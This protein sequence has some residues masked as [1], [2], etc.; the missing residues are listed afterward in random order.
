MNT[1]LRKLRLLPGS[2]CIHLS[3]CGFLL[4]PFLP[5]NLFNLSTPP[6]SHCGILPPL[7]NRRPRLADDRSASRHRPLCLHPF[8]LP[9]RSLSV[10]LV[11]TMDK[12]P[13]ECR[14]MISSFL[15]KKDRLNLSLTCKKFYN[16]FDSTN[17][18]EVKFCGYIDRLSPIFKFFLNE[19]YSEKHERIR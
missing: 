13:Q 12:I 10:P 19:K 17:W 5:Q 9:R 8:I 11:A 2:V 4:L 7:S 3:A 15:T 18:R 6:H 1:D 16:Y 14:G